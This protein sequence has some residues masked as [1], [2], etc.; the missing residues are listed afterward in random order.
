M[1]TQNTILIRYNQE[2]KLI[3]QTPAL[4]PDVD[5][6]V[7]NMQNAADQ[8]RDG[9]SRNGSVA[10][11]LQGLADTAKETNKVPEP[12]DTLGDIKLDD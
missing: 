3:E 9:T 12:F 7:N 2:G 10:D 8:L 6:F 4:R 1:I 5:A 11:T